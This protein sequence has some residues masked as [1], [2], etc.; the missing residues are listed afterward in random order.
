MLPSPSRSFLKGAL[1]LG[2]RYRVV[3]VFHNGAQVRKRVD[4]LP[5]PLAAAL[6]CSSTA[7]RRAVHLNA[8][9]PRCA[10]PACRPVQLT[11]IAQLY[12]E[13]KLKPVLAQTLPLEK[14]G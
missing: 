7:H 2:P 4:L 8:P 14:A 13:G 9:L 11:S 3:L 6:R 10:A 1:G 12:S 5:S